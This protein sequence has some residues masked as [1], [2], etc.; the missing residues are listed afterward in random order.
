MHQEHFRTERERQVAEMAGQEALRKETFVDFENL[1]KNYPTK[2]DV[3]KC[4]SADRTF[5]ACKSS[6][7]APVELESH[8]QLIRN[9]IIP[10]RTKKAVN[11]SDSDQSFRNRT[12]VSVSVRDNNRQYA[13]LISNKV[14][15]IDSDS[16]DGLNTGLNTTRAIMNN[17]GDPLSLSKF[18]PQQ[19]EQRK[20]TQ[21][22]ANNNCLTAFG[23]G[24][25]DRG[26]AASTTDHT[27]TI[28]GGFQNSQMEAMR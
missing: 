2:F 24:S 10:Q 12:A 14:S 18:D 23:H 11:A 17:R 20:S 22:G 1:L 25:I 4:L 27:A 21:G 28:Q 26:T 19:S 7:K 3:S 8:L 16:R 15:V 9:Q 13:A 5:P 6:I